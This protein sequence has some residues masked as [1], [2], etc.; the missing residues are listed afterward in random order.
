MRVNTWGQLGDRPVVDDLL[1]LL[2][3]EVALLR[4]D[5]VSRGVAHQVRVAEAALDALVDAQHVDGREAA[6]TVAAHA[7]LLVHLAGVARTHGQRLG[8]DH[9][10][11][12]IGKVSMEKPL[13]TFYS[14]ENQYK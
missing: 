2:Q 4:G 13:D 10:A 12:R 1:R 9:C 11:V 7:A 14:N 3:L 8:S 6:P 5:A